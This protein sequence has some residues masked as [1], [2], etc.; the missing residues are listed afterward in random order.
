MDRVD[1]EII[2]CLQKD[3]RLPFTDIAKELGVSEGTVRNRVSKLLEDKIIY[4]VAMVDPSQ[5]GFEAPAM[6]GVSIDPPEL[7]SVAETVAAFPEVSYLI[8]VSGEYDLFV[9]VLCKDRTHLAAFLNQKLRRVPGVTRTQTF[10]TLKTYKM[11]YGSPPM[12]PNHPGQA[13]GE[14]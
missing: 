12:L 9:E 10:M 11:A 3:G 7:E 6:I 1:S 5:T 14:E 8:M 13:P 4:I 2:A